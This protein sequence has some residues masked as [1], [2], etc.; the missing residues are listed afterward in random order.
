MSSSHQMQK[1]EFSNRTNFSSLV[2]ENKHGKSRTC[3][4]G[5]NLAIQSGSRFQDESKEQE[6]EKKLGAVVITAPQAKQTN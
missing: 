5:A 3:L 4:K 2:C 6:H 1:L